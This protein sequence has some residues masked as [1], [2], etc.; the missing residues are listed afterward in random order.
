[1]VERSET[2]HEIAIWTIV[3]EIALPGSRGPLEPV[4]CQ[5]IEKML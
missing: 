2:H 1:M 3:D 4:G 5:P